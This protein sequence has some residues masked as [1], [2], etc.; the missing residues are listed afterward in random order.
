MAEPHFTDHLVQRL[1]FDN[2]PQNLK[3]MTSEQEQQIR[4]EYE[5]GASTP[6]LG[7]KWGIS[8]CLAKRSIL[9]AGGK[10]RTLQES[11]LLIDRSY[12]AERRLFTPEQ[13]QQIRAE[14]ESGDSTPTLAVRWGTIPCVVNS[15]IHRGGTIRTR[16]Q[17]QRGLV[18]PMP[19]RC[20][21][22]ESAFDNAEN[23]PI[24]SYFVGLLFADGCI[25][26]D[27]YQKTINLTLKA[28]DA[29]LVYAYRNFIGSSHKVR[30]SS[31]TKNG[32]VSTRAAIGTRS[33]R[34]ATALVRYGIVPRKSMTAIVPDCMMLNTDWWRGLLDGDGWV[35][36][37]NAAA[38]VGVCGTL[39]TCE[40][41]GAYVKTITPTR[42]TV[43]PAGPIFSFTVGHRHACRVAHALYQNCS[44]SLK[45]KRD[46]ALEM[47]AAGK[48]KGL[49]PA[50]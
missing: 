22:D 39:Q 38:R 24:A 20:S 26:E 11:M 35:R 46:V 23:D 4:E 21:L 40:A 17:A 19:R 29:E 7:K 8:R 43:R 1:L 15:I 50:D 48:K 25:S 45:R 2:L 47:I 12:C 16:S 27:G 30:I 37:Y 14:Y 9:R 42:A 36:I 31:C 28:S 10:L 18:K 13:E 3:L 5:A 33:D 32:K 49:F 34:M 41:F 6:Q 44:I